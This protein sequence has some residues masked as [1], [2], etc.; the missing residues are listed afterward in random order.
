MQYSLREKRTERRRWLCSDYNLAFEGELQNQ[1]KLFPNAVSN[2][3]SL[4][5][6]QACSSNIKLRRDND[7]VDSNFIRVLLQ[8]RMPT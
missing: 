6:E 1:R 8:K 4:D 3:K 2:E 7:D 5:T